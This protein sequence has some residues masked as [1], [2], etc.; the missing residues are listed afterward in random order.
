MEGRAIS[1]MD[2]SG[3][4]RIEGQRRGRYREIEELAMGRKDRRGGDWSEGEKQGR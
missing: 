3:V 4:D 2:R 1:Q